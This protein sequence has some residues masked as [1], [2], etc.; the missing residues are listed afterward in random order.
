MWNSTPSFATCACW[1]FS[2]HCWGRT[3]P[4][5]WEQERN[6]FPCALVRTSVSPW[7]LARKWGRM[8]E[9]LS[10][11]QKV[12]SSSCARKAA[13][14]ATFPLRL[15]AKAPTWA[16]DYPLVTRDVRR[17]SERRQ[18]KN[19]LTERAYP[20]R[21]MGL[22]PT[23]FCMASSV[24]KSRISAVYA[25]SRSKRYLWITGDYCGFG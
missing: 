9:C 11:T 2:R 1:G 6:G 19:P 13:C 5:A 14:R 7:R 8:Y 23:T 25:G 16:L 18:R 17:S 22:E 21:L 12:V 15:A 3:G 4:P 24:A 20:K 10:P